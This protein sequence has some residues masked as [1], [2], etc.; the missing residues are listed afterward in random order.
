[1]YVATTSDEANA[2]D[3][4]FSTACQEQI[5]DSYRRVAYKGVR[6]LLS[7]HIHWNGRPNEPADRRLLPHPSQAVRRGPV[8][9]GRQDEVHGIQPG[10]PEEASRGGRAP[11]ELP[12]AHP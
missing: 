4:P 7:S 1:M 9:A 8:E 2:A 3:G 10:P 6:Q 11:V 12:S 5:L